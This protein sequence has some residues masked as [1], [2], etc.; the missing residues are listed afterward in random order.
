MTKD[1]AQLLIEGLL[2]DVLIGVYPQERK[3]KQTIIATL[4]IDYD[5]TAAIAAD[6]VA[7]T[8]NYHLWAKSVTQ[9]VGET[10]FQLLESLA[11]FMLKHLYE[12]DS[13]VLGATVEVRKLNIIENASS[14]GIKLTRCFQSKK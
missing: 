7:H 9:A 4:S 5:V 12:Y 11:D 2:L 3:K 6:D 1:S 13:R 14:C 10:K 8:L